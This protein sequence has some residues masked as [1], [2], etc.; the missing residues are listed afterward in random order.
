MKSLIAPRI[1]KGTRDFLPKEMAKRQFVMEKIKS[2]FISFGYGT[3]ETPALEYAETLLGQYGEEDS[4]LTY[5]FKDKG[6]REIALRYDQTVPF[7]RFV[8]AHHK[9]LPMPF[10]RYQISPVW[11]ADKPGKG[12]YR[13]FY[14]CDVDIIGTKSLLAEGEITKVVHRVFES[15]GFDG[16]VIKFNSRRLIN[17]VLTLLD[18]PTRRQ[19][20][21]IRVLDKLG[22]IER[23]GV[24]Q[25]LASLLSEQAIETL[26]D[27]ITAQGT[28]EQ[29]I[30]FLS[31]YDT[32]EI[33]D[34]LTICDAFGVPRERLVFD[35]SLARG[36]DYYTGIVF[37]AFLENVAIGAV[38]AGGRYDGLCSL[39]SQEKF[40]GVGVAFGFD[41]IM[42]A[43]EEL[44][45][46]HHT[47]LNSR[48]LVTYFDESTLKNS[49]DILNDLQ[50]A[51]ISAEIYFEPEKLSKQLKYAD[52][53]EIPFVVICGPDEIQRGEATIKVMR[54]GKQKR[55]PQNQ[56]TSY[57]NGYTY[58][59]IK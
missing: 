38:C 50:N 26:L 21:I 34:F 49:L 37:E 11:R 48:V 12:R 9:T 5:T 46:F 35:L 47:K 45:L 24:A 53:K 10:K 31:Q 29:K 22:R 54:T 43:V 25:E 2:V 17:S 14:Q 27:I 1:P 19:C 23:E 18:I 32:K 36:L 20:E 7:A 39:F 16:F 13:E 44:N 40:S 59:G 57:L 3:I 56:L 55:I 51:G 41:R 42:L 4:K 52:K 30:G 8:A 33:E 15:L 58:A 6:G 28:N